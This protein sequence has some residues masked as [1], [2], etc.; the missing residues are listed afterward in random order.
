MYK[1][2]ELYCLMINPICLF[3]FL[4]NLASFT[5][6][7]ATINNYISFS[8]FCGNVS[9]GSIICSAFHACIVNSAMQCYNSSPSFLTQTKQLCLAFW[10]RMHHWWWCELPISVATEITERI[11]IL[12]QVHKERPKFVN[13]NC[14]WSL[15]CYI[16]W[17]RLGW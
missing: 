2:F 8:T 10:Q 14:S 11:V 9:Y 3:N 1:L 12:L 17:N 13:Y 7:M 16:Y 6:Y 15:V 5:W 4:V